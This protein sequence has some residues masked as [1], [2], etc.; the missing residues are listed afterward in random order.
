MVELFSN[1]TKKGSK[2]VFIF[3]AG[4][5]CRWHHLLRRTLVQL[6]KALQYKCATQR[7]LILIE[8]PGTKKL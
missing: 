4:L 3:G 6:H 8:K 7:C 2:E 1:K 5:Q